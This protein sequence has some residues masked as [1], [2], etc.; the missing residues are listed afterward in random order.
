MNRLKGKVAVITGGS[1]GIGAASARL[2]QQEGAK[3][4]IFG[5]GGEELSKLQKEMGPDTLAVEGDVSKLQDLER[6]FETVSQRFG[7][8]DIVFANAGMNNP[9]N[10]VVDMPEDGFD[11]T[12]AVNVKGVYFTVQKAIPHLNKPASI[13]LT[14][15]VANVKGWP[16]NTVYAGTKAA[17]RCFA[18][19]MS[20]ELLDRGVRVNVLSPGPTETAV[21][22]PKDVPADKLEQMKKQITESLPV[23]RIADPEEL[24]QA[25]LFLASD[26]SAF[27]LG[28]E[29]VM[30]GGLTQL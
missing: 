9:T 13:I 8:I 2:F 17:I 7:K 24:A 1:S 16:G 23:K 4:A 20:S 10:T 27:M 30:D 29:L 15:S 18:R 28:S 19:G 6:L 21:F 25:A 3:V 14:S 22:S 11:K 26:E 12:F 5:R